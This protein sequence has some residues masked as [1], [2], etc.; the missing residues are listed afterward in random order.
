MEEGR[1]D[2]DNPKYN[3]EFSEVATSTGAVSQ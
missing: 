1:G 3:S 2:A